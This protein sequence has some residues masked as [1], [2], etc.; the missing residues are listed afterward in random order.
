MQVN[1]AF[2][3]AGSPGHVV[4]PRRG[5]AAINELIQCRVDDRLAPIG[6]AFGTVRCAGGFNSLR[7]D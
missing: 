7:M 1:R 4:K 6:G 2:G 5:V 3:D